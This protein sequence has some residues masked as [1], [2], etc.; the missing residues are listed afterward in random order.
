M[1]ARVLI[2]NRG[3]VAI[4]VVRACVE[5]GVRSIAV[6]GADDADCL[7]VAK[8]DSAVALPGHGAAAYLDAGAIV[9][10]ARAA[11]CDAVHPGYGFLSESAE[12]AERCAAA[13][14]A[15]V[16]PSPEALRL[17]GDKTA[18][19]AL[20]QRCGVPVAAG[21]AGPT[22]LADVRAF[23]AA[24]GPGGAMMIKALAGGGGR[25]M[26]AV[27]DAAQL[28][29]S[30][31]RCGS[32][33][34][35]A[36]GVADVYV[37]EL[38]GRARH[39]EV[40]VAGDSRGN[41]IHLFERECSLQRR[42]QKF[43]EIA[44][45][46]WL[47]PTLR[48]ELTDAA[49][50]LV[51]AAGYTGIGT[52]EFLV[53]TTT[54][55]ATTGRFV[56]IEMNPRLQVEHTV[57]EEVLGVDLVAMQLRLAAGMT[58]EQIG[59]G[60]GA[61]APR[62]HAIQ[63]RVNMETFSADGS[64]LPSG[65]TLRVFDPPLGAGVRVETFGY[66]GYTTH[67][68]FDALLAK[69]VVHAPAFS[70]AISRGYRALCEFG[71]DGVATNL[72][73][74]QNL[75]K[76]PDFV[77]GRIDTGFVERHSAELAATCEHPDRHARVG[78]AAHQQVAE[79]AGPAGS[80]AISAPMQGR[81]V[82]FDVAA[83]DLV[84][85][86]QQVAIIEA[87]KMEHV[88][89]APM[90]GIVSLI[91]V[92]PGENVRAGTPL[93][94]LIAQ[95]V[96]DAAAAADAVHDPDR[97]RPDLAELMARQAELADAARP[98]AVARRRKSGQRTAREN[99]S[100][101]CDAGSFVEYGGLALAAQRRRRTLD[102]LR[103]ISPADGLVAG[104]GAVNGDRFADAAARCLV[105]AYDY[106]VF[107]GTQGFMNHKKMDRLLR[108]ALDQRLPT[109]CFAEGGGGRP[110][111]TD[112]MG[113]AGLDVLTF[114]LFA[115]LSALVPLIGIVSGR[116]FAGNAALL[117]CCDVIIATANA[118]I[119][120]GG[121]AMIEGGGLGVFAPDEVGPVSV[122]SPNGVIDILVADEAEAVAAAKRYFSYFQ[123]AVADWH[124]ADQRRLR[125]L[126]PENRLRVYD[127]RPIITTL[128][129]EG[130]VLELRRDFGIGMVTAL[131]RIEGRPLGLIANNPKH[132]SGAIDAEAADKAARF[133][134]LCDAFDIPLLSLTDT[135]GFM[136]GPDAEKTA[137]VRRVSRMFVT[138]ANVT[139][140]FF[141]VVLRKGYG[142]GAQG[143]TGGS[144]HAPFFVVSWPT[145][146]FGGMGLEGA[147][148]L[149]YRN[150]LAAIADEAE[151]K[152]TYD[153]L[154]ADLYER[155]K[156]LSMASFLEIDNVIDPAETRAW[157]MRG[158]RSRPPP[159][160][161]PG[162][163]R[164]HVTTW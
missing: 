148:R 32:E 153:R 22:S 42:H 52:V 64:T 90:S 26:R 99:V 40:Q 43:L 65:G 19:R 84:R 11:G 136:V 4:R 123:G 105:L 49:L 93:L 87:M 143:M 58:L 76:H 6:H 39:I 121:P 56:F 160:A 119:G 3:E 149:A 77:A 59:L 18:A 141:T 131:I 114:R 45:S 142:L 112:F 145:G 106:T 104:I 157:I 41:L 50:R 55:G 63:L 144:F 71:I 21:T 72:M 140:P 98:T 116:C 51:E 134:E 162:K 115:Q 15:F 46:P 60:N 24:L 152:T 66:P 12:L 36:F 33:A 79:V 69:V 70:E 28:E 124:C 159:A 117:G 2:A 20:A 7:H 67:A 61:P 95:E 38:V 101:L 13:G 150:E 102:E 27:R 62:G 128:A 100:D 161:R 96:D 97:I 130:S 54:D 16:G 83:G 47:E 75:L 108:V 137:L 154:V 30:Y 155:G 125:D 10:A 132:L 129:D 73:V 111:E 92:A 94:Y 68:G 89:A 1:L 74:L 25:G 127:I 82:G 80:V 139:V 113:V 163:K 85:T 158:L 78:E 110:G 17:F 29:E 164:P 138:G 103:A 122:Q 9:A 5:L 81:L 48:R 86:A 53:E 34:L 31:R 135:P 44:P 23:F 109:F 156:A 35:A 88:V 118:S 37:E 147:V 133:I 91:A 107:A 151:R 126:V 57:T 8:A 120:M 146:E 14:M